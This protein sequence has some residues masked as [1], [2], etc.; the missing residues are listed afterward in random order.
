MT[1]PAPATPSLIS[2]V[3]SD[4]LTSYPQFTSSVTALQAQ[5]YFNQAILYFDTT[6][7][8]PVAGDLLSMTNLTY[9]LTAHIA[10]LYQMLTAS[11]GS[12]VNG[13]VGRIGSSTQGSVSITTVYTTPTNSFQAWLEQTQYGAM[14]WAAT[15]RFRT[16]RYYAPSRSARW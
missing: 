14:F 13:S 6:G 3:Y 11:D 9:M 12:A 16:A 7:T 2:F 5:N 10:Q 15:A 4:W 8:S 1:F